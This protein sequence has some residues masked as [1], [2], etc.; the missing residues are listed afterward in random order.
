MKIYDK[1]IKFI[2]EHS[3]PIYETLLSEESQYASKVTVTDPLNIKVENDGKACFLHSFCNSER[4]NTEMF[5]SINRATE[6]LVIFGMGL[7]I[8]CDYIKNNFTKL[9]NVVIIEPDLNLFK[10]ILNYSDIEEL[11]KQ[12]VNVTFIINKTK[13]DVY[14]ILWPVISENLMARTEFVFNISYR[15]LYADYYEFI[16][17]QVTT[18]I[19]NYLINTATYNQILYQSTENMIKNYRIKAAPL[20]QCLKKFNDMPYIIVSAG[21]SLNYNMHYLQEVKDKAVIIAVGTA[22]KILDSNGIVPHFRMAYD[23]SDAEYKIFSDL[24]T[25]AAPLIFSD[26]LNARILEEYQGQKLRMILDQTFLSRYLYKDLCPGEFVFAC[27]FS[28]ANVALNIAAKLDFKKIIFMGQD[29]CYT[30]GSLYAKGGDMDEG[31]LFNFENGGYI[32]TVN[33]LD[34][35]VYTDTP[36]LGMKKLFEQ[37]ISENPDISYINAT[38]KGL[39]IEGTLN[40]SFAEIMKDDLHA[41]KDI[42]GLIN[43]L[44]GQSEKDER[45]PVKELA[46]LDLPGRINDMLVINDLRLKNLKKIKKHYDSGL[47]ANRLQSDL[48]YIRSFDEELESIEFYR[49]GIHPFIASKFDAI[50]LSYHYNG[51]DQRVRLKNEIKASI[52]ITVELKRY[53]EFL[54]GLL[55]EQEALP[56]S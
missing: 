10:T 33:T 30:E 21:P 42:S 41:T 5:S 4:E 22:I 40:K 20:T 13:E 53:L 50:R 31:M 16:N 17:K 32:K 43:E 39:N 28:V 51:T 19:R 52:G 47:S 44:F 55:E 49:E 1:N 24:D 15:S 45:D 27:G 25:K 2:K 7:G 38:E 37:T 54:T 6:R 29:L 26:M 11:I 12:L 3:Q 46:Q 35:T 18:S 8:S 34:E 9:K 36:F 48:N 56:T 14:N 23:A